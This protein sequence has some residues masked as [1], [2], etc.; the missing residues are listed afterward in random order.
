MH[1]LILV[2]DE[3]HHDLVFPGTRHIPMAV[4]APEIEDRLIM[5]TAASKTFNI[6]GAHLGNVIIPDPALR[7]R[8]AQRMAGLGISPNSF[9]LHM[10]T[11]AYSGDGARW[12]DA[13]IAYLDENRRLFDD[14][15]NAI[16]GLRSTPLEATYLAWVDFSGTGMT[17]AEFTARVERSAA[18]AANHGATFGAGGGDY[19]RFNFATPRTVVAEAVARLQASFEDLQ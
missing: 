2:S 3:I 11:A 9:G 15:V 12:L 8:F 17:A 1:D 5:L 19:L 7:K 16:P 10:V 13:L 4:A 14:G 6:A 18:I